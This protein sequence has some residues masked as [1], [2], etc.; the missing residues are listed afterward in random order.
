V[1]TGHLKKYVC[2]VGVI[3]LFCITV[4]GVSTGWP[5][6]HECKTYGT[7]VY[8]N[9][10]APVGLHLKARIDGAVVA[11]TTITTAGLYS[12]SIPPDNPLTTAP[13]GWTDGDQVTIWAGDFEARPIFAASDGAKQVNLTA[14]SIA[15]DV[16]RTTW[17]KI[18]AL[19]R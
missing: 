16:R 7:L 18:K 5:V 13:D 2:A 12:F 1:K 14:P 10:P 3:L 11:E 6:L 15:L 8:Q 19:F 17:G 9:G 4:A